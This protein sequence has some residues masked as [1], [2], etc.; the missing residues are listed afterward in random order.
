MI[1]V[2]GSLIAKKGQVK[3]ALE[4]SL[5]HVHRSRLEPGCVLHS[6][7][8]DAENPNRL[9]FLEE[10]A[11]MAALKAHFKVP[12]NVAFASHIKDLATSVA[13]LSIYEATELNG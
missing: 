8:L 9:V 4:L 3:S 6:V 12:D 11:N 5:E 1:I 7:N 10:W 2:T 13:P